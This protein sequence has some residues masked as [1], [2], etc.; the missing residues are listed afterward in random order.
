MAIGVRFPF[1]ETNEGGVFRYTKSSDEAIRTNLISLLTTKK[2]QRVMNNNLYSPLYDQIF[3]E[4]DEISQDI[5]DEKLKDVISKY[6]TEITV[7]DIKY[8]FDETNYT[9]SVKV[10]Y[11][12][13]YLPGVQSSV[14]VGV[15][16]QQNTL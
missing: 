9:L 1:Q 15:A 16:L 3:E 14:E 5:L 11:S 2:K 4:W 13:D 8:T 7:E 6:I 12:I 10:I